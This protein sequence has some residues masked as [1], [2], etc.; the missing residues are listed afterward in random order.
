MTK[1]ILAYIDHF[2][3]KVQPSSWEGLG[4]AAAIAS[5]TGGEAAALILG[6]GVGEVTE[7][8]YHHGA[9]QVFLADDP[10]LKD[11]RP[12]PLADGV[13]KAAEAYQPDLILFPATSRGRSLAG[14]AAVDLNTGVMVDV[15][16]LDWSGDEIIATR[17]IYAGKLLANLVCNTTP[18]IITFRTRAF[19]KPEPDTGRSGTVTP[20]EVEVDPASVGTTITSIQEKAEGISL[21][22]A[23][24]IVSGGRGVALNPNLDPPGDLDEDSADI[25][26]AEQGFALIQELADVLG[27]AV[28]ASRAA[29]DAG[30]IA[31]DHQVGQTGKVVSPDLY[32][33]CGLSGA[34]QHLAGMRSS[35]VI[36]AINKDQDA[37][38]FNFARFGLVGD[39]HA[40][41]PPLTEKL[42]AY[43]K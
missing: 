11:F 7:S 6:E 9:D 36:V 32:I 29:V 38:I 15:I 24:V 21:S 20:V 12:E 10:V 13:K 40:I 39:M 28:G 30:Y 5:D 25:W 14:M 19:D 16:G 33:A 18:Q 31:Y 2:H 35:K 8:A 23:N 43:L 1:K 22:D 4:L 37:P 27:A 26:K 17:P 34:I 41:L 42:K 3:G